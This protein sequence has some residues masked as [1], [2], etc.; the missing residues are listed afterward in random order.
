VS[1]PADADPGGSLR[2]AGVDIVGVRADNPSPLTL[3]GTNTWIVGRDPAW[4]VDPGPDLPAH[5][6]AIDAELARRGGLG[7]VAL[8][9]LHADHAE[10]VPAVRRRHPGAIVAG[11]GPDVDERVHDG[12]RVG[13]LEAIATPG[14]APDHFAYAFGPAVMTGDAVLGAGSVFIAPTPGALRLYLAALERLRE[15][16]PGVLC[17]GHGPLVVD[18]GAKLLEYIAHRRE[19][20]ERLL[21]AL[22]QGSRS[23][24]ALLDAAWSEVPDALRPA[25]AV[26]LA[27]HL[28]K[29]EDERRLPPGVERPDVPDSLRV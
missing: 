18:P 8:T 20:E 7:G 4:V 22:A 21:A 3:T 10:S 2:P 23:V 28:D 29:L 17:P 12:D 16:A 19:R 9:H 13:P 15:R 11:T 5:L 25:A 1:D 24:T 14:H 26:T 27:A 6:A